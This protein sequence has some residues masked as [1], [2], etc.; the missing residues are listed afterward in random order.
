MSRDP[1]RRPALRFLDHL[2]P[3]RFDRIRREI[4]DRELDRRQRDVQAETSIEPP[5]KRRRTRRKKSE[6]K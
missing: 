3:D 4:E 5:P 2:D 6:A 1:F